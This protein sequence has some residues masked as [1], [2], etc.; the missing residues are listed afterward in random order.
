MTAIEEEHPLLLLHKVGVVSALSSQLVE[1]RLT[2]LP[3]L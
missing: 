3:V 1:F 2:P